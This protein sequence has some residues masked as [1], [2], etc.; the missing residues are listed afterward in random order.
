MLSSHFQLSIEQN[1]FNL[2]IFVQEM[3]LFAN[4]IITNEII[5]E[6]TRQIVVVFSVDK[7]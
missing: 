7:E 6:I 1:F 3:I 4:S 5:D 2:N